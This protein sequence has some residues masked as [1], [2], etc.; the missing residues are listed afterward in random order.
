MQCGVISSFLNI[1]KGCHQ[2]DPTAPQLYS[3]GIIS[4]ID[5]ISASAE[6]MME[7]SIVLNFSVHVGAQLRSQPILRWAIPQLRIL[8]H[9]SPT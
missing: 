4:P 6:L 1:K 9:F 3:K 7:K 8:E 5:L 2:G